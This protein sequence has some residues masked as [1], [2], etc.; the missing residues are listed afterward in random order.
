M[1]V[2]SAMPSLKG[3]E[4]EKAISSILKKLP[5]E[6]YRLINN[7]MLKRGNGN[8]VQIDHIVISTYGIFVIETKN[9]KGIITGNDFSEQWTEHIYK[10]KY[11]F[12]SPT[13]QNYG[14]IKALEEL[15]GLP[16]NNF[17][18]INEQI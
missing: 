2:K 14:H 12:F 17:I 16:K 8:T 10:Q 9:Y 7:V 5:R 3:W 11:H 1:L 6:H 18:S 4:G 13:R 15:L